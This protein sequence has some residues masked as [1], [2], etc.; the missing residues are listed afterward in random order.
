MSL[1][2]LTD[3]PV[4][5]SPLPDLGDMGE[6]E[7]RDLMDMVAARLTQLQGQQQNTRQQLLDRDVVRREIEDLQGQ[8]A[9]L[10]AVIETLTPEHGPAEGD[11]SEDGP[12]AEDPLVIIAQA[13]CRIAS[14]TIRLL[15]TN[16]GVLDSA[17]LGEEG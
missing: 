5:P 12:E 9:E 13:T 1:S 2:D 10:H 7:L 8:V 3:D 6:A 17:D 4:V 15:R 11:G 14:N 16:A